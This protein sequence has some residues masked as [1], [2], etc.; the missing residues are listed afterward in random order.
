VVRRVRVVKVDRSQFGQ[1]LSRGPILH[2][3]CA[4][5]LLLEQRLVVVDVSHRDQHICYRQNK[6]SLTVAGLNREFPHGSTY[7]YEK[8]SLV[9]LNSSVSFLPLGGSRSN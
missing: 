2:Q 8:V 1:Y 7:K 3:G 4:I 6:L 5:F 9:M